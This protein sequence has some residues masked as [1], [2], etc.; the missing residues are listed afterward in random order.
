M[1]TSI[2]SEGHEYSLHQNVEIEILDD[3]SYYQTLNL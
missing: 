1:T 2:Y 3:F